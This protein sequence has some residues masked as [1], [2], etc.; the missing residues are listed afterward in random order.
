L[1]PRPRV[2]KPGFS[3]GRCVRDG[4]APKT[5]FLVRCPDTRAL[6]ICALWGLGVLV[7][8]SRW[9]TLTWSSQGRLV[10]PAISVWSLLL[11]LGL[12][13]W[14]P[15]RWGKWAVAA[16]AL[17]LLGLSVVAPCAWI[18]PAYA[19]P[20][21]L[22]EAGPDIVPSHWV[23]ADFGTADSA[24][25][26]VMRLLGYDLETE[27]V[28]PGGRVGITLYWMALAPADR[29]YTVFVHLLGEGELVVAQRDT[30]PGLGRLSTT[31]LEPGFRW[32]DRYVL[33]VPDTAYAPDTAQIQVGLYDTATGDRLQ[34]LAPGEEA[35][36]DNV[37]F[38]RIQVRARPGGV[39]NPIAINFGNRMALVGYDL[40]RRV[41]HLG[42]PV[43]LTLHWRG[44]RRM[45]VNYSVS[46]QLVDPEQRKAAQHDAWP[47]DG[48]APTTSWEP[49]QTLVD[50]HEL[51]VYGDALPGAYDVRVAVYAFED[52]VVTHVPVIPAGGEML[53]DHVVLTQVRVLP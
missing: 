50:V 32:A 43:T 23:D 33:Q 24:S 7:P 30:F 45:D 51:Q 5:W 52:G 13:G 38:G 29:D 12:V 35:P 34:V 25:V 42:E 2:S 48:A 9:A 14:L 47:L 10:F 40:D 37:R 11:A 53:A 31:W 27:A 15:R 20:R 19:L 8:W 46:A 1:S 49:G 18:A 16:F 28:E 41:V 44:L 4:T 26:G 36:R 6:L 21:P 22:T 3:D 39:P 17:F